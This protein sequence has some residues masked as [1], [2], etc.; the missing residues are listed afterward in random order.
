[1][2]LHLNPEAEC[3]VTDLAAKLA[4][5]AHPARL[6]ILRYLSGNGACCCKEVVDQLDLAQ[7]TVSQHLKILVDAGLVT[8]RPER[9]KSRYTVDA[10]EIT[11]L[12]RSLSSYLEGC[13]T[14]CCR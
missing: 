2:N 8:Y 12:S 13:A 3:P 1:M 6:S 7:S 10:D 14:G 5:L 9:P 4:A 11:T